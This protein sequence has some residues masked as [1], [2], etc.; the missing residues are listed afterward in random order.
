M[1][2][3]AASIAKAKRAGYSDAEIAAYIGQDKTLAPK[4]QQARKAGYSDAE[5]VGH[6]GK[7][8]ALAD[9]VKSFA[10]GVSQGIAGIADNVAQ[11]GPMGMVDS[12]LKAAAGMAQTLKG[13]PNTKVANPF[14]ANSAAASRSAY[15]PQTVA[16]EYARAVGQNLPNAAAPGRAVARVANVF[17][18]AIVGE[19][20]RQV[21]RAS[22]AGERGQAV[23]SAVGGLVGAGAAS[24]RPGNIFRPNTD[25]PVQTV[26]GR[27]APQDPAA[28]QAR[29]GEFRA[30]GIEPTLVDVVDDAGRGMV[31]AAASRPTPARD[32]ANQFARGRAL[33]LPDRIGQQAR[34]NMSRD[35]R[36]PDQIRETMGAQRSANADRA[37]GAVRG[38]TIQM[39]PET[40]QALRNPMGR[41]AITEAARR[42]RDP[43][44]RAALNR[45]AT[46]ALDA[47]DT[48]ITIGMADRI[49]RTLFGQGAAAA[50]GGDNDLAATFNGLANALRGPARNAS[51]GY[52]EALEGFGA[53]SRLQE[54][55]GVGEQMLTRNTDEFTRQ[56]AGL[57]PR[58]RALAAA[59]G[60]RAIERQAGEN[61][62]AAPGVA[63][64]IA[65]APEQQARNA[66]LLGPQRAQGL[67]Q[68]MRMEAQALDNA[69]MIA[70]NRGSPTHLN[71]QD[72][73][74]IADG[75]Q[76][77]QRLLRRDFI[78][79][80]LDYLRTRGLNNDQAEAL[81]RM[82]TDPG[83]TD[84]AIRLITQ[85]LGPQA[86]QEFLSMRNAALVGA[87]V[88]ATGFR[89][90][91]E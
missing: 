61:V 53:D 76:V 2:D 28:M 43:E 9:S 48:P 60:R 34:R 8:N 45:L 89:S 64:R 17:A 66:A 37:F 86:A 62:S 31:K 3:L 41:A 20:S 47:P 40:V 22:G 67:Q 26:M 63:R 39:A 36:T 38:E 56:A 29:A 25:Q 7:V 77:G 82:A 6:L 21:A 5:I 69:N 71:D 27:R 91:P 24:V 23:A 83:Q 80:G 72:A 18:P 51:P 49:S 74:R 50:R 58:E 13:R 70:P 68:G 46:D 79:L 73:G 42:E 84:Q 59:A 88:G 65:E 57:A 44:V 12:T 15:A 16:G 78:G 35:P 10:S 4:V 11:A 81:V 54:A 32:T 55:A 75:V 30:A 1:A 33:N 90:A 52:R 19:T 14:S 87:T 85:R